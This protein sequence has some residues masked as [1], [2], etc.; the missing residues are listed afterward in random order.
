MSLWR[1][2]SAGDAES[3]QA[4][5]ERPR[6]PFG[7]ASMHF[8]LCPATCRM[9]NRDQSLQPIAEVYQAV[10]PC[11]HVRELQHTATMTAIL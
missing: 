10:V 11:A 9:R 3:D 8:T 2:C 7:S 6:L 4:Q 1:T 5:S